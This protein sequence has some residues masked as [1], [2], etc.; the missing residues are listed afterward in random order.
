MDVSNQLGRP[1]KKKEQRKKLPLPICV[2]VDT[3]I[4]QLRAAA[5]KRL[6]NL[7][8]KTKHTPK[9][10]SFIQESRKKTRETDETVTYDIINI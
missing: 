5:A 1:R 7:K 4:K 8:A 9:S 10:Y 6:G 2:S 3:R